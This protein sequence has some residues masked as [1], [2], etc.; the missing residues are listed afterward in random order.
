MID[1]AFG[2]TVQASSLSVGEAVRVL[3][4]MGGDVCDGVVTR[5]YRH[6]AAQISVDGSPVD[7]IYD[8]DTYL[9][10]LLDPSVVEPVAE[11]GD[12]TRGDETA[13][14]SKINIDALPAPIRKKIVGVG[15]LDS[16]QVDRVLSAVSDALLRALKSVGVKDDDVYKK[17]VEVQKVVRQSLVK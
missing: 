14:A 15:A 5:L 11:S 2:A 6:G 8:E 12:K 1:S 3:T 7:R 4:K 9:F 17:V 13:S 10:S 16:D